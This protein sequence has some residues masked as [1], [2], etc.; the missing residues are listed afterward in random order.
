[1]KNCKIRQSSDIHFTLAETDF[2]FFMEHW[3]PMNLSEGVRVQPGPLRSSFPPSSGS[4][5]HTDPTQSDGDFDSMAA[6]MQ[7][8]GNW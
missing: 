5:D 2:F 1:M 7:G 8:A 6:H 4:L 3:N